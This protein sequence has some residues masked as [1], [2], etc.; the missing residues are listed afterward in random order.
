MK[1]RFYFPIF[2]LFILSLFFAACKKDPTKN[3][4]LP[5]ITQEGKNTVGFTIDGEVWVPYYKC[6][7]MGNPCGEIHASYGETG[8]AAPNA[9]DFNTIKQSNNKFA[10][11]TITSSGISTITSTGDKID[12]IRVN[13]DDNVLSNDGYFVGP[14]P[15]SKFIVTKI[16]FQN[17]IISGQFEFKLREIKNDGTVTD[18]FI[19]L[20]DG[21]FDFKFNACKCSN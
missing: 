5:P 18:N 14:L 10:A 11:L 9:F 7:F 13:Y 19:I 8:G 15:G 2:F 21:R 4:K 17:Q 6:R 12:S 20:K 16:D 3:A 1:T